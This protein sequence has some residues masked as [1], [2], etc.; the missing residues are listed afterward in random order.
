MQL[1]TFQYRE[2]VR[3]TLQYYRAIKVELDLSGE[4]SRNDRVAL[5]EVMRAYV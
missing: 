2:W 5:T 1:I 4:S 3:A